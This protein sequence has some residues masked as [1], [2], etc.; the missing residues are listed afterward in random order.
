MKF[1][2]EESERTSPTPPSRLTPPN[3]QP[4]PTLSGN[5]TQTEHESDNEYDQSIYHIYLFISL[6]FR[7][8]ENEE[9]NSEQIP[10]ATELNNIQISEQHQCSNINQQTT[11]DEG[12]N[13]LLRI[14]IKFLN[15]TRKEIS[16]NS[17]DTISKIKQ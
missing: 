12:E 14:T 1:L 4:I 15:D 9:F 2:E 3:E 11:S 13:P 10:L 5:E 16:A 6:L 7:S 17:N 8:S